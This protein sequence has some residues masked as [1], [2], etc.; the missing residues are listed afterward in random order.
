MNYL[1]KL[2]LYLYRTPLVTGSIIILIVTILLFIPTDPDLFWHL[3]Y[4]ELTLEQ[5]PISHDP[6]SYTFS[7]FKFY[8]YEWLAHIFT[9]LTYR[10]GGYLLLAVFFAIITLTAFIL[11]V[12]TNLSK[13]VVKQVKVFAI[14]A[15]LF[16]TMPMIGIRL[17]MFSM[18][19]T[20]LVYH[21]LIKYL[22]HKSKLI[23]LIPLIFMI[24]VNLHPGF[25]S[26]LALLSMIT[27]SELAKAILRRFNLINKKDSIY[28]ENAPNLKLLFSIMIASIA[29]TF[30]TPFGY[31]IL[32]QSAKFSLEP[33]TGDLINEWLSPNFKASSGFFF[34]IFS[35]FVFLSIFIRK[36]INLNE[37]IIIL[38]FVIMT[39]QGIRNLPLFVLISLPSVLQVTGFKKVQNY[40]KDPNI[41]LFAA[42]LFLLLISLG[43]LMYNFRLYLNLNTNIDKVF[44]YAGYPLYATRYLKEN[45]KEGNLLNAFG[46]GG[47]LIWEYPEKKLYIDGRM[48][49]WKNGDKSLLKEQDEIRNLKISDWKEKLESYNITVV[50][51]KPSDPIVNALRTDSSWTI[52]YEDNASVLI[53]RK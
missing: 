21:I 39:L 49:S 22:R 13:R 47:Y 30:I 2:Y 27:F 38:F 12:N 32:L 45:P 17:Q 25:L 42:K 15:G 10:L 5:G 9:I 34:Y 33:Y 18:L 50:L 36:R 41:I 44:E 40:L 6:F 48:P 29:A 37:V 20:I 46:W 14:F 52:T 8:D 19:G 35:F 26:G 23:Y 28:G 43:V 1:K 7:E 31:H 24:W 53:Y 51:L 3:K 11:S 16:L 4:G